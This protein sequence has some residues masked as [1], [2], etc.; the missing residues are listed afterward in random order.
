MNT[1][2][3]TD[4]NARVEK[5]HQ[6]LDKIISE[7]GDL[8]YVRLTVNALGVKWM[9]QLKAVSDEMELVK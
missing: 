7:L 2:S 3:T 1:E 9:K 8:S 6:D 4:N 5:L